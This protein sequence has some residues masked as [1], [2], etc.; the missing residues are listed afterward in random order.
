MSDTAPSPHRGMGFGQFV[1]LIAAMM[2]T[3]A[4]AIDSMLPALPHIGEA[5]GVRAI[6][7]A[8]G[9]YSL[10]ELRPYGADHLFEDLADT[11]RVLDA[12]LR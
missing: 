11:E 7:V 5:L 9:Q 12:I 4:L 1:A 10:D 6:G 8:T 3:N 2:A